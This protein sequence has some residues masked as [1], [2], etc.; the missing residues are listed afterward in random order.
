ML[1]TIGRRHQH[2]DVL[3]DDF[4]RLITEQSFGRGAEGLNAA[5]FVDDDH[6]VGHCIQD[7]TQMIF[8]QLKGGICEG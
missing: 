3:P 5:L 8:A 1:A 4:A 6:G 7:R 2:L